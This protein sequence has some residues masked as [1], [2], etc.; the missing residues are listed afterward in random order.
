MTPSLII[1]LSLYIYIYIMYMYREREI[2]VLVSLLLS[3]L[4]LILFPAGL[5]RLCLRRD[6]RGGRLRH[7]AGQKARSFGL[8]ANQRPAHLM[9][10]IFFSTRLLTQMLSAHGAAL[11]PR[12]LTLYHAVPYCTNERNNISY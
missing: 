11:A 12:N 10:V 1:H 8:R 2:H 5:V 4:L 9:R 6:V 7:F 3:L